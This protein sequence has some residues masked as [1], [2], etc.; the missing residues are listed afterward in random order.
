MGELENTA[1]QLFR[2]RPDGVI[3]QDMGVCGY[4]RQ[5]LPS[6]RLHAS[7]QMAISNHQGAEYLKQRGFDRVVLAREM[8][9]EEIGACSRTGIETEVFCHGALCVA[10]S[11]LCLFSSMVGG[12]SGNRGACA[13]PCRMEYEAKGA[14]SAKGY[15]LSPKDL[16]AAPMLDKLIKAGASSLKIEG[17]LKK[18]EYVA[19]VTHAYRRLLDGET[20]DEKLT[21]ELRQ[22]FNRGGFTRGYFEGIKDGEFLSTQRPGHQGVPVGKASGRTVYLDRDVDKGDALA[23]RNELGDEIPVKLSGKAGERAANPLKADGTVYRMQSKKLLDEVSER[24]RRERGCVHV[25]ARLTLRTG[26]PACLELDDG[27]NRVT[28]EGETVMLAENGGISAERLL[29]QLKKTG[30]TPYLIDSAELDGDADAFL[31]MSAVNSLR[32]EALERLSRARIARARGDWEKR[33]YTSPKA[34]E[35]DYPLPPR[36]A[37]QSDD[38]GLLRKLLKE[39]ADEAVHFPAD[40]REAALANADI[41]GMFLYLP[42]VM[43]GDTL[44]TLNRF[45]LGN[46]GKLKGVY[47]S[48]PGQLALEWPGE[49]RFDFSMNIANNAALEFLGVGE[50][51]YA[52]SVELTCRELKQLAGNRELVV[53]GRV[54]L[55]HL[56][57]CP[58]NAMRGGGKHRECRACDSAQAGKRLTDLYYTDRTRANF[59]FRRLASD[60]GC[61]IDLMN[62]VPMNLLARTAELPES[63]VWRLLLTDEDEKTAVKLVRAFRAAAA[64]ERSEG[65]IVEKYT[66]GHYFRIT[67]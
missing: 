39:G 19:V 52:P 12:R 36:I 17:R 11:G 51:I 10:C 42:P 14:A 38:S 48:N 54:P 67:E 44:D 21:D 35:G 64:G 23:V 37:V 1:E 32:R 18:P 8:S 53:Y 50:D 3:V 30:G 49:R 6:L 66:T 47:I 46:A 58:L 29:S 41:D 63:R 65:N 55:M 62:S 15:L 59:P 45:A 25:S 13:Q 40:L 2:A 20:P 33:E 7:T 26:K 43:A 5:V 34:A 60:D 16:M 4:F 28:A 31:S 61:V 24:L 27:E 22:V 9:L 57:H 56:R